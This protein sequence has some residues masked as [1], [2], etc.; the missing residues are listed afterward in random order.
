MY[1]S[2]YYSFVC[3]EMTDCSDK[4]LRDIVMNF[5]IAG[6]DTTAVTMTWTCYM[7]ATHPDV[8]RKVAVTNRV[9]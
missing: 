9:E 5:I 3:F 7:L 1:V 2:A 8:E 4:D 6:R